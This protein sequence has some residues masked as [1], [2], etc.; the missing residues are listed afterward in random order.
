MLCRKP[1]KKGPQQFGCGQC[2][3]CRINRSRLWVGRML[4]ESME[5]PASCFVTLTYNEEHVPKDGNLNK[6]H[7][8][9][10]VQSVRERIH[11]R[12]L[13][14][15]LV[16]EYGDKSWRPHFH[17]VLFGVSPTEEE[18]IRQC[19][20]KGFVLVG[21]AEAASMQYVAGYVVKKMTN[22]K[23]PRLAG[24]IPEFACMSLRPGI[25]YGIVERLKKSYSTIGGVKALQQEGW[26]ADQVRVLGYK[27]PL[28]R[29]L[30]EQLLKE[31]GFDKIAKA[32]HNLAEL[33]KAEKEVSCDVE[34]RAKVEQQNL[35][36]WK[37]RLL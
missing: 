32:E 25:G 21:T 23:D 30:K 37:R 16:G 2:T 13:R 6:R 33:N 18:L 14:Y 19:W 3:P 27:Y 7:G 12:K 34:R 4:L 9:Q 31:L 8:Q 1:F 20:K 22:P 29:Y 15:Y 5:H 35:R 10:F 36:Q 26:I 28:G 24:R 11:P 17:L